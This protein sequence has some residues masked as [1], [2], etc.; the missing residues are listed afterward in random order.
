MLYKLTRRPFSAPVSVCRC[1][2]R[3]MTCRHKRASNP[4][5]AGFASSLSS[6]LSARLAVAADE[7]GRTH[8]GSD[9]E[10]CW[11]E[12][13]QLIAQRLCL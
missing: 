13:E 3:K 4:T 11:A 12:P 2:S 10:G 9:A 8:D 7:G 5:S 1:I 6:T